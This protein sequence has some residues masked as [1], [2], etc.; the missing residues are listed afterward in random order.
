MFL[1]PNMLLSRIHFGEEGGRVCMYVKKIKI[2]SKLLK[3]ADKM[4]IS[5]NMP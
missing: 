2:D 3:K 1:Y 5:K 4:Y